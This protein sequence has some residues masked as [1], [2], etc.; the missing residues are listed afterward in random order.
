MSNGIKVFGLVSAVVLAGATGAVWVALEAVALLAGVVA[1]AATTAGFATTAG[2]T[3]T[4]TGARAAVL[5]S[6][7]VAFNVAF[8][9]TGLKWVLCITS[10]ESL[11]ADFEGA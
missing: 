2:A 3:T 4:G 8:R 9:R 6:A 5:L 1:A 10:D 7:A 11:L